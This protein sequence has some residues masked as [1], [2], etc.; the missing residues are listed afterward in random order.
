MFTL[1][2]TVIALTASVGLMTG[3]ASTAWAN[4]SFPD[5]PL[6]LVVGYSPGGQTDNIARMVATRLGTVLGQPVIVQ[7]KEGAAS[8]IAYRYVAESKPDGYTMM[9]GGTSAHAIAP[10]LGK[11]PYDSLKDF[12]AL[13][14]V[15]TLP[16]SISVNT[17]VPANNL[18]ELIALIKKNPDGYSY[19]TGGAGGIEHL[20]GEMFKQHADVPKLL[21]VPFKGGVPAAT[22][23]IGKQIPILINPL[24]TVFPYADA[25]KLKVLAVTSEERLKASPNVPTAIESGIPGFIAE[26]F[27]V[28]LVPAKTPDN[29]VQ[30]LNQGLDKVMSDPE[31]I[32]ALLAMKVNPQTAST[33]AETDK[34]LA[35]EVQRW[36]D[37]IKTAN[38][39]I[40]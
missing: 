35:T 7:N 25:G 31:F 34:Y 15:S 37:A 6:T 9:F 16:L 20:T 38:V 29:V 28:L 39:T 14:K 10:V 22:A 18:Q 24:S 11:V 23:V 8:T 2:Q 17:D 33:P 4:D 27:N 36:T 30:K 19:A 13:G 26:G 32:A 1:R 3:S 5:K 12:R 40:N 21:H